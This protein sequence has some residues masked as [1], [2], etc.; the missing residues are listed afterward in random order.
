M[1][2]QL[3]P[4]LFAGVVLVLF[5]TFGYRVWHQQRQVRGIDAESDA[6]VFAFAAS[7]QVKLKLRRWSTKTLGP[8]DLRVG[9]VLQVRTQPKGVGA[10]L[11]SQW[12]FVARETRIDR[13]GGPWDP[14]R[15]KWVV[16]SGT[17]GG[18][19]TTLALAPVAG[20]VEPI[21]QALLEAGCQPRHAQ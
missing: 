16:I 14:L 12:F 20:E 21:W 15:R 8:M 2:A 19:A 7:V 13:A 3:A 4:L 9:R 18:R 17:S 6:E 10:A 5:V 11:G 1:L